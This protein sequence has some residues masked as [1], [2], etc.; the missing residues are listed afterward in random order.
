MAVN[1]GS[2]AVTLYLGSQ[3]VNAYLGGTLVTPPVALT[4]YFDGAVDAEWTELGN[5]WLDDEHTVAATALPT[6]AD[7]VIATASIGSN[8]GSE[9]MVV[10]F[11]LNSNGEDQYVM[12]ISITVTGAAVFNADAFL[13]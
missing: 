6:A 10:N 8:S 4:L 1:L 9:P 11:T 3:S 13:P 2:S 5:W 12:Q 7:S